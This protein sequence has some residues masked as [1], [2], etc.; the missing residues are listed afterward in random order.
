M[1]QFAGMNFCTD[2]LQDMSVAA[3]NVDLVDF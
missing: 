1:E 2:A 3:P